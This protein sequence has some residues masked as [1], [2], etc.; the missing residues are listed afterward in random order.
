[1]LSKI[2]C[3]GWN[4]NFNLQFCTQFQDDLSGDYKTLALALIREE[5]AGKK[6]K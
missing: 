2:L 6:K 1:M 5:G 3:A 4:I